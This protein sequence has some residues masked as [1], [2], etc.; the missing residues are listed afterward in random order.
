MFLVEGKIN[1]VSKPL[2]RN[3]SQHTIQGCK[4]KKK[5]CNIFET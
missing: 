3:N 1:F 5:L 4:Q 2:V